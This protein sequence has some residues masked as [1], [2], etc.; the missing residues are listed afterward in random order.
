MKYQIISLKSESQHSQLDPQPNRWKYKRS[1][2]HVSQTWSR[3]ELC[4]EKN[5]QVRVQ[6]NLFSRG[7]LYEHVVPCKKNLSPSRLARDIGMQS[8]LVSRIFGCLW[9]TPGNSDSEYKLDF[10]FERIC[11]NCLCVNCFVFSSTCQLSLLLSHSQSLVILVNH[12]C[13][14]IYRG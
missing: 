2:I 7:K 8:L 12:T 14:R 5:E 4:R 3:C 6:L 13:G 11:V 9:F 1:K 10:L